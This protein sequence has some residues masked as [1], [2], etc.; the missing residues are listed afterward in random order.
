MSMKKLKDFIVDKLKLF[1]VALTIALMVDK[2][3]FGFAIVDG[4]SMYPTLNTS[5]R[6]LVLKMPILTKDPDIGDIVI[7]NPPNQVEEEELFIKRVV[8]KAGD[9]FKFIEGELFVNDEEISEIYISH[10]A[11]TDRGYTFLEGVVPDGMIYV[12]GDNRNDSNDSRSFGFVD[13]GQ[14][15]GKALIR[16]WPIKEIT[17]FLNPR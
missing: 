7:F 4:Q 13:E 2:F 17:V 6:I 9:S 1:L 10:E 12:L 11:I 14:I 15:K 5:D 8:A 3:L 16:I